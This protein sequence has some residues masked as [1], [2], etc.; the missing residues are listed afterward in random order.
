MQ[1]Q[2]LA[3]TLLL[4]LLLLMLPMLNGAKTLPGPMDILG[5]G[6]LPIRE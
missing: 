3:G 1:H 6:S 4:L 2:Q 5:L